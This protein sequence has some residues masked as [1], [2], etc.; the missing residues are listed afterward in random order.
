MLLPFV[1][2]HATNFQIHRSSLLGLL[3]VVLV[4][5]STACTLVRKLSVKKKKKWI[6]VSISSQLTELTD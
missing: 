6:L 1:K 2:E 5:P 3:G 4:M